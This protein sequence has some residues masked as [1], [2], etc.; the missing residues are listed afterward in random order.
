MLPDRQ[1]VT[2]ENFN[3]LLLGCSVNSLPFVVAVQGPAGDKLEDYEP[4]RIIGF[5]LVGL[6]TRGLMGSYATSGEH[7][8][9][10]TAVV[11]REFRRK[12]VGTALLDVVFTICSPIHNP[13]RGY[14]VVGIFEHRGDPT[15]WPAERHPRR[16]IHLEMDYVLPG[17]TSIEA[18]EATDAFQWIDDYLYVNFQMSLVHHDDLYISDRRFEPGWFDRLVYRH[19]CRADG[20]L[21]MRPEPW[22]TRIQQNVRRMAVI[23]LRK[24]SSPWSL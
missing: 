11:R 19:R 15:Y 5:A 16:F 7:N 13:I 22:R 2:P 10:I 21:E 6:A 24:A 9:K 18:V 3:R 14:E 23:R 8:G 12:N 1:D 17:G 20:A 4:D